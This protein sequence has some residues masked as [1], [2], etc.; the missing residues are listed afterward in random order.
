VEAKNDPGEKSAQYID[1]KSLANN[2]LVFRIKIMPKSEA[3][4]AMA[5]KATGACNQ[6]KSESA[7]EHRQGTKLFPR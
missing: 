1:L 6:K 7:E 3:P 2:Q 5:W 4:R